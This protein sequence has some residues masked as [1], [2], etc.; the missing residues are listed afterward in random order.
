M[1]GRMGKHH[2]FQCFKL[3]GNWQLMCMGILMFMVMA[4]IVTKIVKT[5][6][7]V[8]VK[9]L[10]QIRLVMVPWEAMLV[11]VQM[12][13]MAWKSYRRVAMATW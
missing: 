12:M 3:P 10:S 2:A 1:P 6:R 13:T 11:M 7:M 9:D 5:R 8:G 4:V